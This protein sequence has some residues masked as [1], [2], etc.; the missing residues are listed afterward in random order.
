MKISNKILFVDFK[1]FFSESH[2]SALNY[3]GMVDDFQ[4]NFI[5]EDRKIPSCT[6]NK[7]QINYK[8]LILFNYYRDN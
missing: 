2:Y 1:D 8:I 7:I 3:E 4:K 6:L 5:F